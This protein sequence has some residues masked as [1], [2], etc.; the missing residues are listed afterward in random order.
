M[1]LTSILPSAFWRTAMA[2]TAH[3]GCSGTELLWLTLNLGAGRHVES[4]ELC[5]YSA[6]LSSAP[7]GAFPSEGFCLRPYVML[8]GRSAAPSTCQRLSSDSH[9]VERPLQIRARAVR[10]AATQVSY[11]IGVAQPLS[12]HVDTYGTGTIP[13]KEILAKVL[14]KFDFRP[15]AHRQNLILFRNQCINLTWLNQIQILI[16]ITLLY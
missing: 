2:L 9:A 6:H 8:L 12:V 10:L 11:A 3:L 4:T 14:E 1:A 13:D 5:I 7:C 15:G 16:T